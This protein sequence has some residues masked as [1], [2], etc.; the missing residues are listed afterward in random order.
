MSMKSWLYLN[1]VCTGKAEEVQTTELESSA[2]ISSPGG[3]GPLRWKPKMLHRASGEGKLRKQPPQGGDLEAN[4]G[5][6]AHTHTEQTF[7]Q[8]DRALAL[9]QPG[10]SR[11]SAEDRAQPAGS[12]AGAHPLMQQYPRTSNVLMHKH[13]NHHMLTFRKISN[14]EPKHLHDFRSK[15]E[16]KERKEELKASSNCL[17]GKKTNNPINSE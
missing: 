8:Q 15:R 7:P 3:G 16:E 6:H 9:Q 12:P 5:A 13:R 10:L 14:P 4:N 11:E 1:K 2:P 17:D